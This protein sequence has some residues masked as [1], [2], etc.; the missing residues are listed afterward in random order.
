MKTE[1]ER[2]AD[3]LKRA[4]YGEAWHGPSL[5]ETLVGVTAKQA[6]ARPIAGAHTIWELVA[7]IAG[8]EGVIARRLGGEAVV[9]PDEGDFPAAPAEP[10]E[11]AWAG[12]IA[13]AYSTHDALVAQIAG[14]SEADLDK[15]IGG[16]THGAWVEAHGATA[17]ALYHVGQ[18]AL[19]KKAL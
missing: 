11:D 16:K 10:S 13:R 6:L 12:L 2:I 14:L 1:S 19:L 8:W 9:E 4:Y 15:R 18:I 3:L 7:H 5:K 17:H